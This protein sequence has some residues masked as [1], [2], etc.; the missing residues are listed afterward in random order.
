LYFADMMVAVKRFRKPLPY[1][2]LDLAPYYLVQLLLALSA[3]F[4]AL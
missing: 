1:L 3:S 2:H 4:P